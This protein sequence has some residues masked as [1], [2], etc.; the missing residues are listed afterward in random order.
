[1]TQNNST[2]RTYSIT[3][4]YYECYE[5]IDGMAGMKSHSSYAGECSN[6]NE[7]Y[8]NTKFAS[9]VVCLTEIILLKYSVREKSKT[10]TIVVDFEYSPDEC[11]VN[12]TN[13][14]YSDDEM[15]KY[16]EGNPKVLRNI[17]SYLRNKLVKFEFNLSHF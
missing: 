14:N 12:Y 9:K 1:M 4:K 15:V 13:I 7:N 11:L 16:V 3:I 10:G 8:I 2:I 5:L 6:N 17:D